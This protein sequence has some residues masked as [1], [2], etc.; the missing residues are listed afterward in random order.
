MKSESRNQKAEEKTGG[1]KLIE[2]MQ[3]S[4]R[5]RMGEGLL[6]AFCLLLSEFHNG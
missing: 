3:T 1:L 2:R 6:S 4:T 5:R